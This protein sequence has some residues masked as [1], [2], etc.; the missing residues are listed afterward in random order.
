MIRVTLP[1][2]PVWKAL[3]WAKENCPN[4]ITNDAHEIGP[5]SYDNSYIDYFFSNEADAIIFKLKWT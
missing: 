4:Y 1:Y 5:S 3:E 2:D